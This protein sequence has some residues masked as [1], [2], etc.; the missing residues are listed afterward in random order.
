MKRQLSLCLAALLL[1]LLTACGGSDGANG[2]SAGSA[3]G[4]NNYSS[5]EPD[6]SRDFDASVEEGIFGDVAVPSAPAELPPEPDP[7]SS[8]S[9]L[10]PRAT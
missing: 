6:S 9:T 10:L 5:W 7:S 1:V 3:G 8:S 4:D 2:G